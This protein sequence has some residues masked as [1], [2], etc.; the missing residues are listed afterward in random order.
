M[1]NE[2]QEV[3]TMESGSERE[4]REQNTSSPVLV[5]SASVE[6]KEKTSL[7]NIVIAELSPIVIKAIEDG[8]VSKDGQSLS[9][10]YFC[11]IC[12]VSLTGEEP[13]E[14]HLQGSSHSKKLNVS[15]YKE[16]SP[17]EEKPTYKELLPYIEKSSYKENC[18]YRDNSPSNTIS[19]LS[20]I[21]VSTQLPEEIS[22]II[23]IHAHES[24]ESRLCFN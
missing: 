8:H 18:S 6:R 20:K 22:D 16:N 24:V 19:S 4:S 2:E 15:P 12:N 13:L 21:S 10:A 23:V 11:N 17:C 14:Q 5:A 1:S 7:S 9:G 3:I